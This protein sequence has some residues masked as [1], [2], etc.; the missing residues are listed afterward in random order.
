MT[1][2]GP[3]AAPANL[4][5]GVPEAG[6]DERVARRSFVRASKWHGYAHNGAKISNIVQRKHQMDQYG[7]Y[8]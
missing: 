4:V 7:P 8:Q 1:H 2:P 5:N 3:F 6:A